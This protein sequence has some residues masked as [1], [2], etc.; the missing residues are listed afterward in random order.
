MRLIYSHTSDILYY[1]I[2]MVSEIRSESSNSLSSLS[3]GM[4]DKSRA[5][6][7]FGGGGFGGG[8]GGKKGF[9]DEESSSES[10]SSSSESSS[11]SSS[12]EEDIEEEEEKEGNF[13]ENA[14]PT[15]AKGGK[16]AFFSSGLEEMT[17]RRREGGGGDDDDDDDDIEDDEDDDIEDDRDDDEILEVREYNNNDHHQHRE[18]QQ[19]RQNQKPP[20]LLPNANNSNNNNKNKEWRKLLPHYVPASELFLGSRVNNEVVFVDYQAQF[21]SNG[22]RKTQVPMTVGEREA[23]DAQMQN[24]FNTRKKNNGANQQEARWYTTAAGVRTYVT[25]TGQKL[26]GKRAYDA[27]IKDQQKWGL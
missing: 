5:M 27:S 8:F 20:P 10:F 19:Q 24:P 12:G 17:K 9:E 6:R 1:E 7:E 2:K 11:L 14:K 16:F 25:K 4:G 3:L 15:A 18:H 13:K 21:N 26:T 23:Y 22:K